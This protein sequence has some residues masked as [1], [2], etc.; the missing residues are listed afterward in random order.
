[1]RCT[2]TIVVSIILLHVSVSH[3]LSLKDTHFADVYTFDALPNYLLQYKT[4]SVLEKDGHDILV[5]AYNPPCIVKYDMAN[6]WNNPHV[7]QWAAMDSDIDEIIECFASKKNKAIVCLSKVGENE[8]SITVHNSD[9]FLVP[10]LRYDLP[11]KVGKPIFSEDDNNI[12]LIIPH[13]EITSIFDCF[14]TIV[15]INFTTNKTSIISHT[16][17][18]FSLFSVTHYHHNIIVGFQR[19]ND[20]ASRHFLIM[21]PSLTIYSNE[22]VPHIPG[23]FHHVNTYFSSFVMNNS[24]VLVDSHNIIRVTFDPFN[25]T[26]MF[27]SIEFLIM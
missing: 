16:Y 9:N 10:P 15:S 19:Y 20:D 18:Y 7:D 11:M 6:I 2:I 24:L 5:F 21:D 23:T 26:G 1:M 8:S 27:N 17:R 3:A 14:G 12:A 13:S 25:I 4:I 22:T